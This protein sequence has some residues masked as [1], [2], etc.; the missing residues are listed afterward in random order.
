M[1]ACHYELIYGIKIV[2]HLLT[3]LIQY[4]IDEYPIVH[5][6]FE[7]WIGDNYRTKVC[8]DDILDSKCVDT[9]FEYIFEKNKGL[10]LTHEESNHFNS[11]INIMYQGEN[12]A[13]IGLQIWSTR[14]INPFS[15]DQATGIPI[16][17]V[18]SEKSELVKNLIEKLELPNNF[19]YPEIGAYW[20]YSTD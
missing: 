18:T 13:Y 5:T 3:Q 15:K 12:Y 16:P 11:F 9:F 17:V 14:D 8:A 20:M 6:A 19:E 7:D 2:P 1:G 10:K 4:Y